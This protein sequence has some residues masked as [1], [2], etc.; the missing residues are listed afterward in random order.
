MKTETITRTEYTLWGDKESETFTGNTKQTFFCKLLMDDPDKSHAI[1]SKEEY[2][3]MMK[4]G[5]DYMLFTAEAMSPDK[6]DLMAI[7]VQKMKTYD[8][9]SRDLLDIPTWGE[10]HFIEV[11]GRGKNKAIRPINPPEFGAKLEL[12]A[13]VFFVRAHRFSDIDPAYFI[14]RAEEGDYCIAAH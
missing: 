3:D 10:N 14:K 2:D 11:Y 9:V 1:I 13:A 5:E 4:R 12:G 7:F 8:F 6:I